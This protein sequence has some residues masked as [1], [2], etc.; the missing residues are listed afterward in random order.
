MSE[1]YDMTSKLALSPY[2]SDEDQPTSLTSSP[3]EPVDISSAAIVK[4]D[5]TLPTGLASLSQDS[6]TSLGIVDAVLGN[7]SENVKVRICQ[8]LLPSGLL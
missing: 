6:S 7:T 8:F 2:S 1:A 4:L 5:S 3:R